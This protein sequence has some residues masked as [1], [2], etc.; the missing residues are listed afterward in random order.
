MQKVFILSAIFFMVSGVSSVKA[1]Q[2]GWELH[3]SF[4][5][6]QSAYLY[7]LLPIFSHKNAPISV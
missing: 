4:P 2:A 5:N 6:Q 7:V 3:S 1:Q